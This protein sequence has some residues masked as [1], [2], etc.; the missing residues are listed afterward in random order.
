[1]KLKDWIFGFIIGATVGL[2]V[3]WYFTY[4]DWSLNPGGIF[5]DEMGTNWDRVRETFSSWWIPVTSWTTLTAWVVLFLKSR[6][7]RRQS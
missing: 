5:Q 2:A 3:A 1:M 6:F 4:N 7:G